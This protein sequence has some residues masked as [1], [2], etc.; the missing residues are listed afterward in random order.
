MYWERLCTWLCQPD[1]VPQ[2]PVRPFA[3]SSQ[4]SGVILTQT[5]TVSDLS[6]FQGCLCGECQSGQWCGGLQ[7]ALPPSSSSGP[8]CSRHAMG[9]LSLSVSGAMMLAVPLVGG[10]HSLGCKC[11]PGC[12]TS[13]V[14]QM[15]STGRKSAWPPE[16]RLRAPLLSPQ[17]ERGPCWSNSLSL[18]SQGL[19]LLSGCH[20]IF[21]PVLERCYL[22]FSHSCENK[23]R[24][25][26]AGD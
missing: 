2:T 5:D 26:N 24:I 3:G 9:V 19:G 7:T 1:V 25:Y 13:P 6:D 20:G 16:E 23:Y 10:C 15:R 22:G 11:F 21:C 17:A 18:A 14:P 12:S 8:R 4:H